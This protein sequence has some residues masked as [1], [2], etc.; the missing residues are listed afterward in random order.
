[1]SS[2]GWNEFTEDAESDGVSSPVAGVGSAPRP[3][4]ASAPVSA[5]PSS[6]SSISS[7]SASA[8]VASTTASSS[9]SETA[10][11]APGG[12]GSVKKPAKPSTGVSIP[13]A[14]FN[15]SNAV[16]SK[17]GRGVYQQ[18]RRSL[19]EVDEGMHASLSISTAC[20][21]LAAPLS[22]DRSQFTRPS[23]RASTFAPF[24]PSPG[25]QILG[26][27]VGGM[28]YALREAGFYAG[29][30]LMALVATCSDF[31]VQMIVRLGVSVNKKYYEQLVA[32][33]FGH[34][35]YVAVS[36]AMGIFAYGAMCAYLIGVGACLETG[37]CSGVR[38]GGAIEHAARRSSQA[39]FFFVE[40]SH[41][42][43]Q[44]RTRSKL[45]QLWRWLAL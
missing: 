16:R 8:G 45:Q 33:Q 7:S 43:F 4:P 5:K 29:M 14:S 25:A 23:I 36:A 17:N 31:S 19:A 42:S 32:S 15:L 12:D 40:E 41:A 11:A 34:A 10:L 37:L 20:A 28:P 35:G 30:I 26:A 22:S 13:M 21:G 38:C 1:M 18:G 9:S 27:G 39:E 44:M 24:L 3:G 6:S 2:G